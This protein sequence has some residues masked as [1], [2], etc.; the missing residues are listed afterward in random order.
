MAAG[1]K[2]RVLVADDEQD[3][4]DYVQAVLEEQYELLFAADG[5]E[6][7]ALAR[8]EKPD[9]IILD[10]QMPG[11]SGF[12]VFPE[13]KKDSA[14]KATPVI[15]LTGIKEKV[16]IGFSKDAMGGFM[17]NEPDAYLEKPIDA[18]ELIN[19]VRSCLA[20]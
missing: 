2:K 3:A 17:G 10:V 4:R 12:D 11:K 18:K 1:A 5:E 20:A 13:L 14:L 19:A 7:L 15:M 6:A 8:K 16:G 9:L